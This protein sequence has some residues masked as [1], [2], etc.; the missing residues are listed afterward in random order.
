M[1]NAEHNDGASDLSGFRNLIGLISPKC[2]PIRFLKPNRSLA[3]SLC[4]SFFIPYSSLIASIA[5][6]CNA[7]QAGISPAN[8][9]LTMMIMVAAMAT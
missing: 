6:I 8:R 2:K 3:L 1:K 5:L 4:S 7:L 9:P